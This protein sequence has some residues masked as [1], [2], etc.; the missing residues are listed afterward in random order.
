V[1]TFTIAVI[2]GIGGGM[3]AQIVDRIRKEGLQACTILAL[4]TNAVAAQR[5]VDAGA[6]KGASGE[7][8]I[9]VSIGCA[10]VVV[11]P[12]GI[13]L[14]NSML[15]EVTPGIAEHV[16]SSRASK[17]L[18]PLSQ[19]HITLVGVDQKNVNDLIAEAVALIKRLH[20]RGI[21]MD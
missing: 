7:N 16:C 11:G 10:D 20:E 17:I 9:R 2:D 3:G 1:K 12:I 4:G 19:P 18:L 6:H 13:V 15:G 14:A 8:A 5:M 21:S